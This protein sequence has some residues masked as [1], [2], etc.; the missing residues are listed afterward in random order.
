MAALQS[1]VNHCESA[2]RV[3]SPEYITPNAINSLLHDNVNKFLFSYGAALNKG[4]KVDSGVNK[5]FKKRFDNLTSREYL[6]DIEMTIDSG[7]YQ[8]QQGFIDKDDTSTMIDLYHDMLLTINDRID[9]AFPLDIAPGIQFCA[10]DSWDEIKKYNIESLSKAAALPEELRRKILYIHHFRTPKLNEIWKSMLFDEGLA[11]PF[12]NFATGGLVSFGNNAS[13]PVQLYIIPLMWLIHYCKKRKLDKFRFHVLGGSEW[14]DIIFHKFIEHHIRKIHNIDV[15][16]TYDSSSIFQTL[17]M[18]RTIIVPDESGILMKLP[19]KSNLNNLE[20]DADWGYSKEHLSTKYTR[21]DNG[22]K[23]SDIIYDAFN[24]SCVKYGMKAL[25]EKDNP[26]YEESGMMNRLIYQYGIMH[27]LTVYHYVDALGK[28]M[29]E[30]LYPI[31]ESERDGLGNQFDILINETLI[32]LN[33]ATK[34]KKVSDKSCT[35]SNSLR[36]LEQMDLD[37][38]DYFI[39]EY[40]NQDDPDRLKEDDTSTYFDSD[41]PQEIAAKIK[42]KIYR[43]NIENNLKSEDMNG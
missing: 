11:D 34:S 35:F 13:P 5:R 26:I 18:A 10:Y 39:N 41:K 29:V 31:Y 30:R 27:L 20:V 9:Y 42:R 23:I 12:Y 33:N 37:K 25:T 24:K 2:L 38:A 21:L 7:G 14:K 1:F 40:M 8:V 43:T 6:N 22:K 3:Y 32:T 28:E 15:E 17:A 36:E 4:E 19:M 16:I